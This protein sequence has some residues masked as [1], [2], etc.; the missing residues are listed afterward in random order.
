MMKVKG[1]LR[2]KITRHIEKHR[3]AAT[4]MVWGG[5]DYDRAEIRTDPEVYQRLAD[6]I[7]IM[8]KTELN[9]N[10]KKPKDGE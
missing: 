8:V 9:K 5:L 2:Q 4:Q 6:S 10:K 1:E 3:R 7:I